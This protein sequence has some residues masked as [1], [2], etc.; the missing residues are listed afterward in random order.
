VSLWFVPL[1]LCQCPWFSGFVFWWSHWVQYSF[2]SS[3]IVCLSF[4]LFF[5]NFYCIFKLWD[6]VFHLSSLLEWTSTVFCLTKGTFYFQK[7]C[8]ILFSEIFHIIVK[9]FF[10]IFC[11]LLSF[12][13]I[14]FSIV[15]FLS[16]WCFLKS[17][18]ISFICYCVLYFWCLKFLE[19][20]LFV[21]VSYF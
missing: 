18:L 16:L 1:L 15:S 19:C 2:H 3:W 10:Y 21:L 5:F 12:I 13:Y 17:S 6:S 4:R 14:F 20:I 8:L 11:C 9:L 7:F